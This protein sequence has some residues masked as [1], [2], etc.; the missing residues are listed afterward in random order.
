MSL[1]EAE[2]KLQF[3]TV[4]L[5]CELT[6]GLSDA[7]YMGLFSSFSCIKLA[8]GFQGLI[9]LNFPNTNSVLGEFS[10][11]PPRWA[12]VVFVIPVLMIRELEH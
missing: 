4:G 8:G 7:R 11:T 5:A 10:L 12:G 2:F 9:S 1:G 3:V 6:I